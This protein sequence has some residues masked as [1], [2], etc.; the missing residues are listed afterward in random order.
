MKFIEFLKDKPQPQKQIDLIPEYIAYQIND[1]LNNDGG[2]LIFDFSKTKFEEKE[3]LEIHKILKD[4]K[5][6]ILGYCEPQN[7]YEALCIFDYLDIELP[8]EK[9][10]SIKFDFSD[11]I[12]TE[13]Y[14]RFDDIRCNELKLKDIFF[15][16]GAGIKNI[17]IDKLILRPVENNE[18]VVVEIEGYVNDEGRLVIREHAFINKIEFENHVKGDGEIFFVGIKKETDGDFTNRNLDKLIFQNCNLSNCRFLNSKVD[19]TKFEACKFPQSR[20]LLLMDTIFNNHILL[21]ILPVLF[22]FVIFYFA[23]KKILD[24]F[25]DYFTFLPISFPAFL[26]LFI[27]LPGLFFIALL[28]LTMVSVVSNPIIILAMKIFDFIPFVDKERSRLFT[29]HTATRDEELILARIENYKNQPDKKNETQGIKKDIGALIFI[30]EQLKKNFEESGDYQKGGDF[31]FA[32]RYLEVVISNRNIFEL[33]FLHIHYFVDGF[34]QNFIKPII[35][36]FL[37]ISAFAFFVKPNIDFVATPTTPPFLLKTYEVAGS[38]YH[39]HFDNNASSSF[40]SLYTTNLPTSEKNET[41]GFYTKFIGFDGINNYHYQKMYIP[42]LKV[43]ADEDSFK[44]RLIYSFSKVITPITPENKKWFTTLTGK[45]YIL[46]YL[47]TIL[48][49]LFMASFVSSLWQRIRR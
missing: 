6:E 19:K 47:E 40:M 13:T 42:K 16:S 21:W 30:Y 20:N 31:F 34:G 43:E 27:V 38:S 8:K 5:D 18:V 3:K 29:K 17:A 23:D 15:L 36:F 48:L 44:T 14:F 22:S 7:K 24:A 39:Y 4:R 28:L 45:A 26:S 12:F 2:Q 11:C 32:K 1:Y 9:E 25:N 37:T 10:Y 35:W 33:A 49:W 41:D 46:G